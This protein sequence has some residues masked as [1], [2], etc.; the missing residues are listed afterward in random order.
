[1][2]GP[3]T[4]GTRTGGPRAAAERPGIHLGVSTV[5]S[6]LR[7]WG[8]IRDIPAL[9]IV[10]EV[11]APGLLVVKHHRGDEAGSSKFAN[12]AVLEGD[13]IKV[14]DENASSLPDCP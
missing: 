13:Q 4:T 1:M 10:V 5:D 14:V 12:V 8:T 6:E 3:H 7:V 9:C 11:A 2:A